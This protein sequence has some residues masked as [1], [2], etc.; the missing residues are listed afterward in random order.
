MTEPNLIGDARTITVRIPAFLKHL[1]ERIEGCPADHL[2][3]LHWACRERRGVL[4]RGCLAKVRCAAQ[5]DGF[6]DE[7][8]MPAQLHRAGTPLRERRA[9]QVTLSAVKPMRRW[10]GAGV[11][12]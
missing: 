2:G 6:Y 7:T 3:C 10:H 12:S 1:K 8:E 11:I 5:K 9:E 4:S